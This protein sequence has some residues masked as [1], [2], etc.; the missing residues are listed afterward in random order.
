M[1]SVQCNILAAAVSILIFCGR[2]RLEAR[3]KNTVRDQLP[4]VLLQVCSSVMNISWSSLL[5]RVAG[6][7]RSAQMNR[8][9]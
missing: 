1:R 4:G 3:V 6:I 9:S 5:Q 8:G 2:K 7:G